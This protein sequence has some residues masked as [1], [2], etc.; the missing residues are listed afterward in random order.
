MFT[1]NYTIKM[2]EFTINDNI[3]LKLVDNQTIIYL[4]NNQFLICKHLK[5]QVPNYKIDFFNTI[6]EIIDFKN[7]D[8]VN[9]KNNISPISPEMAFLGHCSNLQVWVEN[10]YNT[11]LLHST[12]AFPL[13]EKLSKLGDSVAKKVF[14][15]EIIKKINGDY[16]PTIIYLVMNRY[17]IYFT[18]E[19][20]NTLIDEFHDQEKTYNE[21]LLDLIYRFDEERCLLSSREIIFLTE[22][23]K[24]N[25]FELIIK[26]GKNYFD[27]NRDF[28]QWTSNFLI[29]LSKVNKKYLE[30]KIKALLCTKHKIVFKEIDNKNF[31]QIKLDFSKMDEFSIQLYYL[32]RNLSKRP[33]DFDFYSDKQ[34]HN[35]LLKKIK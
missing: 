5:I 34:E 19:E 27:K 35:K 6:D 11:Q 22:H 23:P 16:A 8:S 28:A 7:E 25:L 17:L 9:N 30:K 1:I 14:K 26:Y 12:I 20:L 33:W 13:L 31:Y 18:D 2:K 32:L 10:N 21:D 29:K 3:T 24:I 4:D 15:E